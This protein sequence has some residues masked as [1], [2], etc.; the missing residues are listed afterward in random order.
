MN[1]T[2][3]FDLRLNVTMPPAPTNGSTGGGAL[4]G[5]AVQELVLYLLNVTLTTALVG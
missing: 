2:K 4:G 1:A 3:L 5:G